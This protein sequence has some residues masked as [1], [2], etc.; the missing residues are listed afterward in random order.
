MTEIL[1]TIQK[2]RTRICKYLLTQLKFE[3]G[4]VTAFIQE[5]KECMYYNV[6]YKN[7]Y[8]KP[9]SVLLL[10]LVYLFS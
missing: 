3:N 5:K 9:S 6:R 2:L 7:K 1:L 10:G 4:K 8:T